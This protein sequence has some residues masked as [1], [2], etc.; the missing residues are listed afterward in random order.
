MLHFINERINSFQSISND[1]PD[2][3]NYYWQLFESST[4]QTKE[5]ITIVF[6]QVV[7][8]WMDQPPE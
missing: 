1:L 5:E 2:E 6:Q 3:E 7:K 8:R 4:L